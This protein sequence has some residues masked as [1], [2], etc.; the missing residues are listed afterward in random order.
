MFDQVFS[1]TDLPK[2][3]FLSFLEIILSADNA[4]VLGLL[5]ARLPEKMRA[6]ALYIGLI[7]AFFIRAVTILFIG[8]FI[9]YRWIQLLGAGYL[10]FLSFR[11]F[12]KKKKTVPDSMQTHSFWK[13]VVMIEIFDIIFA[14]D[15]ILAGVAL[16]SSSNPQVFFSKLWI[17]YVGGMIGLIGIRYA[18]HL[19][20]SV[21][22]KFPNM[23]RSAYL[24]IGWIAIKLIYE[25]FPHPIQLEYY[26]WGIFIILFLSGF[27]KKKYV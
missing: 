1:L 11:H 2:I 7:S 25:I 22:A 16:I 19:F 14:I 23:E 13:A 27:W 26:F 21:I 8:L 24:L 5:A 9:R 12:L 17:V 10:L 3:A 18:A 20:T 4:I 6:K 15:S